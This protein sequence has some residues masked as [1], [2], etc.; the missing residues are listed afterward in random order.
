MKVK[1]RTLGGETPEMLFDDITTIQTGR[2][3]TIVWI[4]ECTL[5]ADI[6]LTIESDNHVHGPDASGALWVWGEK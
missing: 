6:L 5:G 2:D 4:S 3:G 1:V